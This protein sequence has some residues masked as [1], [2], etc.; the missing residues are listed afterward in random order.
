MLAEYWLV[1]DSI[2]DRMPHSQTKRQAFNNL[3]LL[4]SIVKYT[5][6]TT[7]CQMFQLLNKWEP[8]Y[9]SFSFDLLCV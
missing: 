6:K 2:S 9:H 1:A 8:R 5:D 3:E 7:G 4:K